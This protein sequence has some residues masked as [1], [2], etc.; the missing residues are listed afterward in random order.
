MR[1]AL[2]R[3]DDLPRGSHRRDEPPHGLMMRLA[4]RHRKLSA[5]RFAEGFGIEVTD[6]AACMDVLASYEYAGSYPEQIECL[7][8][9]VPVTFTHDDLPG[10]W[11]RIGGQEIRSADWSVATRRFCPACLAEQAYH[12]AWFDLSFMRTCPDHGLPIVDRT[13][14]GVAVGFA[15]A[16]VDVTSLGTRLPRPA[17][18]VGSRRRSI[19]AYALA[20]LGLRD[21]WESPI[22]DAMRLGE[23][24]VACEMMGG[25]VLGGYNANRPTPEDIGRT[26]GEVT[27]AGFALL[28]AGRDGVV[29]AFKDIGR[30]AP[31]RTY[32]ARKLFG[33]LYNSFT[34]MAGIHVVRDL[35]MEAARELGRAGTRHGSGWTGQA[36]WLTL[37]Q[38]AEANKLDRRSVRTVA[39]ALGLLQGGGSKG[40]PSFV[41]ESDVPAIVVGFRWGL[42]RDGAARMLGV[43]PNT[44]DWLVWSCHLTK[45]WRG[46]DGDTA[47]RF[48]LGDLIGFVEALPVVY[49]AEDDP[50]LRTYPPLVPLPAVI[51]RSRLVGLDVIE[52]VWAGRVTLVTSSVVGSNLA[53]LLVSPDEPAL[54][55]LGLAAKAA[56]GSTRVS[57]APL[58]AM[59]KR[60]A[61]TLLCV[62]PSTIAALVEGGHLSMILGKDKSD[63][64]ALD[65][66]SVGS[67]G[68]RYLAARFYADAIGIKTQWLTGKAE[69]AGVID[70]LRD[71]RRRGARNDVAVMYERTVMTKLLGLPADPDKDLPGHLAWTRLATYLGRGR[72]GFMVWNIHGE[73]EATCAMNNMRWKVRL[74]VEAGGRGGACTVAAALSLSKTDRVDVHAV[75]AAADRRPRPAGLT[76][77]LDEGKGRLEAT[78]GTV[79][80]GWGADAGAE[81]ASTEEATFRVMAGLLLDLRTFFD[82]PSAATSDRDVDMG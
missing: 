1:A 13:E 62:S 72:S 25:A 58:A 67:F 32:G 68:E 26:A 55:H 24:I 81:V 60:E 31:E 36:E 39:D 18:R 53:A 10:V 15:T 17:P 7:E 46:M 2:G 28:D 29:S 12:R 76:F 27:D 6:V 82:G 23:V 70:L 11:R 4:T 57:R 47:D 19:E 51:E 61:C 80:P 14:D 59:T 74:A 79:V 22:L 34:P 73:R 50:V 9:W 78:L 33:W 41:S 71:V 44:M 56:S 21:R 45:S 48:H 8:G 30:D 52:E 49:V 42:R 75:A 38:V 3:W 37:A 43:G 16:S 54:L 5:A 20:R 77:Q 65:R 66:R 35:L 63:R 69:G 64:G 40:T